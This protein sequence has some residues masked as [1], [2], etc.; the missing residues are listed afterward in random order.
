MSIWHMH[1]EWVKEEL[2]VA[3]LHGL[4]MP[5]IA[6]SSGASL[7]DPDGSGWCLGIRH[8]VCAWACETLVKELFHQLADGDCSVL[9]RELST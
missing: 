1:Y 7:A 5:H 6:W 3:H 8:G 4:R 2:A 9:E